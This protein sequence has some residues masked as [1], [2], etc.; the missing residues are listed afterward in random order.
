MEEGHGRSGGEGQKRG[1]ERWVRRERR[2]HHEHHHHHHHRQG[3]NTFLWFAVVTPELLLVICSEQLIPVSCS[4]WCLVVFSTLV[5]SVYCLLLV[6]AER[7]SCTDY[8]S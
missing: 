6:R 2:V 5:S 8:L 3:S 7:D 1:R 4:P